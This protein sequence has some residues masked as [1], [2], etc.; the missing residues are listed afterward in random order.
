MPQQLKYVAQLAMDN[1]YQSYKG[2]DDFWE[3][4]DFISM[5]GNT[6]ASMYLNFYQQEYAM[7]RQDKK[8]EVVSFDAGWLLGQEVSVVKDKAGDLSA[9]LDN[10]VMT[11]PYDRSSIGIQSVFITEPKSFDEIERISL[12]A[13]WQLKYLPK[14]DKIFFYSNVAKD[15][16]GNLGFI[17]KGDCNIKKIRVL[18]VP[19]MTDGEAVVAD[20][21]IS[22][23]VLKTVVAMKQIAEGNVVDQTADGNGNKIM[24]TEIDKNTLVK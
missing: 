18:Y 1:F 19:S 15:G 5:C 9:D 6:I 20:G 2:D 12:S 16:K 8:D 14:V 11:F 7:L 17:N 24:Q 10:P 4:S 21:I 23:A 13:L 22:D 3:L